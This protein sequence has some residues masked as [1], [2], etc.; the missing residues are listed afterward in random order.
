MGS[1]AQVG[2]RGNAKIA[3]L[4]DA[5]T[6]SINF[7]NN[8]GEQIKAFFADAVNEVYR[9]AAYAAVTVIYNEL[10]IRAP[11]RS[12]RLKEAMYRFRVKADLGNKAVFYAGVNKK[13]APHWWLIENGYWQIYRV[14]F[15]EQTG[16]FYTLENK[17]LAN[18]K[19]IP[20]QPYLAPTFDAKMGEA[21][22]VALQE[23]KKRLEAKMNG[24]QLNS[25]DYV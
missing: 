17:P 14:V 5:N 21:L 8:I 11:E 10:K 25:P 6:V 22:Q 2:R 24:Q 20:P 12:G 18:P 9:P 23:I 3:K 15:N 13:K 1:R 16:K 4:Y 7:E 19:F